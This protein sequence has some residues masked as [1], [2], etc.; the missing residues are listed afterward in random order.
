MKRAIIIVLDSVGIGAVPDAANFGDAGSNTLVN[1]KKRR[2][3]TSLPNLCALGLVNNVDEISQIIDEAVELYNDLK[4]RANH[5]EGN[6]R[7][8]YRNLT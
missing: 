2:P 8:Y 6:K 5:P 4:H 3:E 7:A 1:I